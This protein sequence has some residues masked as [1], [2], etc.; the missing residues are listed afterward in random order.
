MNS[1]KKV[2]FYTLGCRLNFFETSSIAK[3]DKLHVNIQAATQAEG[4]QLERPCETTLRA[5]QGCYAQIE[6]QK[7]KEEHNVELILGSS[8]KYKVLTT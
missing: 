6:A 8:E 5:P 2:S 3:C 4:I 1:S 7:I